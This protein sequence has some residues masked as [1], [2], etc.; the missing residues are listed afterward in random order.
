MRK[1]FAKNRVAKYY[2]ARPKKT[3]STLIIISGG[4][5]SG[6]RIKIRAFEIRDWDFRWEFLVLGFRIEIRSFGIHNEY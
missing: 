1:I 2:K 3:Q 5:L 4:F 6:I